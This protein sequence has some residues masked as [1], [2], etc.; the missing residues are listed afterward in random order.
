MKN[1][2]IKNDRIAF[3]ITSEDKAKFQQFSDSVKL[4]LSTVARIAI[5]E[6]MERNKT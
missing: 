1:K 5:E 6:Y 2:K 3:A 4:P